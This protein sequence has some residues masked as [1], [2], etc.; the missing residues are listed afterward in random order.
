MLPRIESWPAD[1]QQALVEA[2]HS[3]EAECAGVYH[4]S[5]D[6]LEAIDRGLEDVRHGRF[7]SNES[8][9]AIRAKFRGA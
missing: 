8:I 2:A 6:E 7:A 1:D 3:I 5:P 9:S 4:A